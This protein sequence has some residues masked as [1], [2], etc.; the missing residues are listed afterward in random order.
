MQK[1]IKFS[2]LYAV[3]LLLILLGIFF[4]NK[5]KESSSQID[6]NISH[7]TLSVI[8][9]FYSPEL[10]NSKTL[11]IYLPYGY[12]TSDKQYPV[13]YM[14]DGQNLFDDKTASYYVE[15]GI[16]ETSDGLYTDSKTNG[17]IVVG[18]DSNGETRVDEYNPFKGVSDGQT[19]PQGGNADKYAKFIVNTLKP[20]IDKN[21][22]T[23]PD[24]SNTAIV[25]SSYGAVIS[26]YTAIE[27]NDKF[28]LVGAFSFA[29]N[30]NAIE[31]RKYLANNLIP[32]KL[33][34]TK[35]YF[36]VG[37]NDFALDSTKNAY[38]IAKKNGLTDILYEEDNGE[39]HE[40]SWRPMFKNC[41]EFFGL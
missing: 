32:E 12:E 2:P 18:I 36:Y 7:G 34:D 4:T 8:D 20:Y 38:N 40:R 17:V 35:I 14:Q 39:H 33:K 1:K 19:T 10:D 15:W 25:G 29:D 31:M 9:N 37:T 30:L 6:K 13:I 28:G 26:L 16:D 27:Y 22:K 23:L 24:R 11:R 3:L 21:Y 5:H 41:V